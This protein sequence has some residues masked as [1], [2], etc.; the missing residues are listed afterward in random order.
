LLHLNEI[1]DTKK[2]LCINRIFF[3]LIYH[4]IVRLKYNNETADVDFNFVFRCASIDVAAYNVSNATLHQLLELSV[5]SFF[6][7]LSLERLERYQRRFKHCKLIIIDEKFMIEQRFLYKIDQ[8]LRVIL[9][10]SDVFFEEMNVLFCDDF[11]QLSSVTN[12]V[13]YVNSKTK[14]SHESCLDWNAYRAFAKIVVLTRFMRQQDDSIEVVQFRQTLIELRK[15]LISRFNW[16][17]LLTRT[18]E[19]LEITKWRLFDETLRLHARNE[20]VVEY[21]LTRLRQKNNSIMI[22]RAEHTNKN[23]HNASSEDADRLK[24][25]LL[26]SKDVR[27]MLTW[28]MWIDEELI[29]ETM[30]TMIDLLWHDNVKDSFFTLLAIVLVAMN[31]YFDLASMLIHDQHVV[32]ITFRIN[33]WKNKEIVCTRTQYFLILFA[34]ITIHKS[35]SLT[36]LMMMLN[37]TRKNDFSEQNYVVLSRVRNIE[38]VTFE[39][40]FSHDRFSS[41]LTQ[42]TLNRIR[43]DLT[44]Q[45][46]LISNVETIFEIANSS[47][48]C[49]IVASSVFESIVRNQTSSLKEII[50]IL[51]DDD[52][53]FNSLVSNDLIDVAIN[54]VVTKYFASRIFQLIEIEIDVIQTFFDYI[55]DK[56]VIALNFDRYLLFRRIDERLIHSTMHIRLEI[57]FDVDFWTLHT[58]LSRQW[59]CF[60]VIHDVLEILNVVFSEI[61]LMSIIV[62]WQIC[63]DLK[64][65]RHS[66]EYVSSLDSSKNTFVFSINLS[67]QHWMTNKTSCENEQRQIIIYNF[68]FKQNDS[69]FNSTLFMFLNFLIQQTNDDDNNW[70]SNAWSSS[71]I[72]YAQFTQQTNSSS[73]ELYI[74]F[75]ILVLI[76]RQIS[77][78][79]FVH[80]D[81]LRK[82]YVDVLINSLLVI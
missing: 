23:A 29:N 36:L 34:V 18:R 9:A 70:I 38:F 20:D 42:H 16:E 12:N 10:R 66:R 56:N 4:A 68:L 75:N 55:R 26:F 62:F 60:F 2:S 24:F 1:V 32:F 47:S 31:N 74:I 17:F 8:R 37:F 76:Q 79:D 33:Q 53:N 7:E 6:I 63:E 40:S 59:L 44:R 22:L 13:L 43:D 46:L 57:E 28:N 71:K 5:N 35:Q 78:F 21:N 27:V 80:S 69:L 30:N 54:D 77:F 52:E 11:D 64:R 19:R 65:Q 61:V 49:I 82:L 50:S 48:S 15:E 41:Q 73:C 72:V 39:S 3:H 58:L 25:E 67:N 45:E 51:I 81:H 14:T